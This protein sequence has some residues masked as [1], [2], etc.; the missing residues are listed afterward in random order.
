MWWCCW[1]GVTN[2]ALFFVSGVV[3][4][5]ELEQ[6]QAHTTTG[7][8]AVEAPP[9]GKM[10]CVPW[11]RRK[12]V[13]SRPVRVTDGWDGLAM[14]GGRGAAHSHA[15]TH[16]HCRYFSRQPCHAVPIHS[17][18]RPAALCTRACSGRTHKA[19]LGPSWHTA[20]KPHLAVGVK[21]ETRQRWGP[22]NT[23][24]RARHHAR[25]AAA[26]PQCSA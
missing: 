4:P 3:A 17:P 18:S 21:D 8:G 9:R 11:A 14:A 12:G 19:R 23:A 1:V 15:S 5:R 25:V 2:E 6:S 16:R 13:S 20:D 22:R 10:G 26:V 7:P 24:A